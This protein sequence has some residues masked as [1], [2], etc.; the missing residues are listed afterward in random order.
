MSVKSVEIFDARPEDARIIGRLHGNS[1]QANY[2]GIFPD[3]YMAN[4]VLPERLAYWQRALPAGDYALVRIARVDEKPVG[5]IAVKR[6]A[7][8]GYDGTIEHLHVLDAHQGLG[9]GRQLM[10]AAAQ[11]LFDAGYRSMCLWV[12]EA[13]LR[14]INFYESLGGLTDAHGT[15]KFAGGDAPDRR[16]VWR[17]LPA[18]I[19]ACKRERRR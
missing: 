7:D 8:E 18:L 17:D 13:N 6:H 12:F 3:A 14:A 16:I 15:D 2:Q 1:W 5:F 11:R 9:L 10:A 19:A 4:E